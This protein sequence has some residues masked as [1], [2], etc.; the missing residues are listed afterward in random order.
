MKR[1][2]VEGN[3][4]FMTMVAAMIFGYAKVRIN[5]LSVNDINIP[6]PDRENGLYKR[7]FTRCSKMAFATASDFELTW[8]FL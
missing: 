3:V 5:V 6:S 4:F 7:S 1:L 8:S 2:C